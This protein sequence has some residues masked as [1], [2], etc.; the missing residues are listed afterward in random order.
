MLVGGALVVEGIELVAEPDAKS[1]NSEKRIA[2]VSGCML[3]CIIDRCSDRDFSSESDLKGR[4]YRS[5]ST[6]LDIPGFVTT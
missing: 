4:R 2:S 1:A 6:R 5:C 3:V